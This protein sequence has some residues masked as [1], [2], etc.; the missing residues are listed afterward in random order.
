MAEEIPQEGTTPEPQDFGLFTSAE[1]PPEEPPTEE[2][3]PAEPPPEEPPTEDTPEQKLARAQDDLSRRDREL[4]GRESTIKAQEVQL[5]E[6]AAIRTQAKDDP[7]E[8]VRQLGIDPLELAEKMLGGEAG[9]PIKPEP[10]P[11]YDAMVQ[12]ISELKQM[13][14]EQQN[15]NYTQVETGKIKA[16]INAG[17]G[18]YEV[19]SALSKENDS[20]YNDIFQRSMK[21]YQET[22][23]LPDY[24]EVIKSAEDQYTG[25]LLKTLTPLLG[26]STIKDKISQLLDPKKT[27]ATKKIEPPATG[28]TLTNDMEG[29]TKKTERFLTDEEKEA[30]AMKIFGNMFAEAKQE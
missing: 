13:V 9:P 4:Y 16:L 26:V 29:E 14:Q 18:Q 21:H 12:Q 3:P 11:Q 19:L 28:K 8:A 5:Q 2:P 25:Q 24:Q 23:K 6:L 1:P 30:E 27:L 15:Q 20:V 7:L 22:G 10:N 17:N